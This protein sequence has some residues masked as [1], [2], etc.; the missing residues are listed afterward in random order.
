MYHGAGE[1]KA[2]VVSGFDVDVGGCVRGRG[3]G[4]R[5]HI[6]VYFACLLLTFRECCR[7][8]GYVGCTTTRLWYY[9]Y[10]AIP[11]ACAYIVLRPAPR[12]YPDE[13][14]DLALVSG[15]K[16]YYATDVTN[17]CTDAMI[18]LCAKRQELC[19][20]TTENDLWEFVILYRIILWSL[21]SE[22]LGSVTAR[23]TA[24]NI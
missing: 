4:F 14:F 10:I 23:V 6:Y 8:T 1:Y 16:S 11:Y 20:F 19:E 24:N 3:K 7:T 17:Y 22:R 12:N 9:Y 13:I 2:P 5:V 21:W 18:I 15:V